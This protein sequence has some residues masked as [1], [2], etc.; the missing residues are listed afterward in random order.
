MQHRTVEYFPSDI[1]EVEDL[2]DSAGANAQAHLHTTAAYSDVFELTEVSRDAYRDTCVETTLSRSSLQFLSH[3][4]YLPMQ[5][6]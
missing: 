4:S 5:G 2:F 1:S 3:D 6:L